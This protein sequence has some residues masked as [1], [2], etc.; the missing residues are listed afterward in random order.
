MIRPGVGT[1]DYLYGVILPQQTGFSYTNTY[2]STNNS[3]LDPA[4]TLSN[5]FPNGLLP[6]RGAAQGVNTNLGRA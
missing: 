4:A 6:P 3:Y 1:F 5:P 2:V